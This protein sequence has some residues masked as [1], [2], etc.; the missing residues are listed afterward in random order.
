MRGV[1]V[2]LALVA[3]TGAQA[4][5]QEFFGVERPR[6]HDSPTGQTFPDHYTRPNARI[7]YVDPDDREPAKPV[8]CVDQ[9]FTLPRVGSE[10]PRIGRAP[11]CQ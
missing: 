9:G 1:L 4:Q 2:A 7:I 10:G 5:Q 6:W 3:S 11:E 8:P